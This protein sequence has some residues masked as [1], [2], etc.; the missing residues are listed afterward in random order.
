MTELRIYSLG[1]H[2]DRRSVSNG[3]RAA[4]KLCLAAVDSR[5]NQ[6]GLDDHGPRRPPALGADRLDQNI[7]GLLSDRGAALV[8]GGE[9]HAQQVGVVDIAHADHFD[10]LRECAMPR[11]EDRLHG[12]GG[13]RVVVAEDGVRPRLERE[14][15]AGGF[16]AAGVVGGV[17]RRRLREP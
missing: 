9:R 15:A 1:R 8:D 17:Q 6:R 11:L 13:G 3:Y 4:R 16:V 12:A 14:Q 2:C 7:R 5:G 10:L